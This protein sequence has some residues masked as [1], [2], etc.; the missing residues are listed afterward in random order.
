MRRLIND[1]GIFHVVAGV[2]DDSDN[3][4][5]AHGKIIQTYIVMMYGSEQRRT[6]R[7]QTIQLVGGLFGPIQ[8]G[9]AHSLLAHLTLIHVSE[10]SKALKGDSYFK[11][12]IFKIVVFKKICNV[13]KFEI[14][15]SLCQN[16][17]FRNVDI[18]LNLSFKI[19]F[20]QQSCKIFKFKIHTFSF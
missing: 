8:A 1:H 10:K 2:G 11:I 19:L 7:L 6:R 5:G 17:Y 13:S 4:I 18:F 15:N 20:F 16:S 3:G 14:H 9:C 12:R